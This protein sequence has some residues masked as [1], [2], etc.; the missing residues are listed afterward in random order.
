MIDLKEVITKYPE[1]LENSEKLKAYLT[2]LYP[3]E[4]AK[5]SIIVAIFN[6]GIADEIKK[7]SNIDEID[8]TRYCNKLENNFGFSQR[9]SIECLRIWLD[10]YEKFV[11]N[12]HMILNSDNNSYNQNSTNDVLNYKK[13]IDFKDVH[14]K[15]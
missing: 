8:I 15:N 1:C 12:T 11:N 3:S 13:N 14:S 10:T 6:S 4:K 9:L 5:V 7:S 2:D